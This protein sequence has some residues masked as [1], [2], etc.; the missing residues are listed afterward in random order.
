MTEYLLIGGP[1]D[2]KQLAIKAGISVLYHDDK[3][4]NRFIYNLTNFYY[5]GT[6]YNVGVLDASDADVIQA[7]KTNFLR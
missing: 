1:G 7:I 5:L 3:S 6:L 4:G 2:G